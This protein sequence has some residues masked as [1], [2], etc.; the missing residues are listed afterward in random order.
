MGQIWQLINLDMHETYGNWGKLGECLFDT[1]PNCLNT[2]L[3]AAPKLP[4]CDR[5]ILPF[6]PGAPFETLLSGRTVTYFPQKA[7]Q[8]STLV[9]L[10]LEMIQEIYS[11]IEDFVDVVCLSMT[12]QSLWNRGRKEIYRYVGLIAASLSWVGGCIICVGNYLENDDIP[13]HLLSPEEKAEFTR[14]DNNKDE[15]EDG[16][17]QQYTLYNYPWVES[18]GYRGIFSVRRLFESYMLSGLLDWRVHSV[19]RSL[20]L[21]RHQYVRESSLVSWREAVQ[22]EI[23]ETRDVGFGHIVLSRICFSTSGSV[24]MVYDGDIHHGVW[25]GDRLDIVAESEI[26]DDDRSA[27]T[28]VSDEVLKEVEAIW[29]S[30]YLR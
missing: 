19:L 27:W 18:A 10:P 30:E 24:A 9:N 29:R 14:L 15:D 5:L 6:K 12:C 20:N 17:S 21:S 28:D 3:R 25:A 2:T 8:S 22:A 16:E 4:D 7:A 1:S 13:E 23:K 11:N 26:S